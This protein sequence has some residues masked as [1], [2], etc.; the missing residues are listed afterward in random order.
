MRRKRD[1]SRDKSLRGVS[2]LKLVGEDDV[3]LRAKSSKRRERENEK[4]VVASWKQTP[5]R[6]SSFRTHDLALEVP[7]EDSQ[8]NLGPIGSL[9][10]LQ[11]VEDDPSRGCAEMARRRSVDD[12]RE[13]FRL[14]G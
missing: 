4:S 3:S 9:D 12:S 8:T 1:D 10:D 13:A 6:C 2:F 5:K 11:V 14:E 7:R